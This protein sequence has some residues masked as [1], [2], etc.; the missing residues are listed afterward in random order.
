VRQQDVRRDPADEG[1]EPRQGA[2]FVEHLEVA[3]QALVA[4]EPHQAAG[5]L[6]LG[7]AHAHEFLPSVDARPAAPVR[8]GEA[9]DLVPDALQPQQRA[10]RHE[11]HVV[12]VRED[13]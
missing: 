12:G 7:A 6:R 10:R 11:L 13:A 9:V 1:G 8:D 2:A 3:H 5:L 4:R